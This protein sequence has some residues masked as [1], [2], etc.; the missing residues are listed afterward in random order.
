MLNNG[1]VL[2][3]YFN[4]PT[5]YLYNPSTNTWTTT[6]NTKLHN[7]RSDEETWIKL[8]DGSILSYDIY[9]SSSG[10]FQAQH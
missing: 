2:A 8:A 7:D 1:D 5:T 6:A 4:S 3:G 10:T 9:S